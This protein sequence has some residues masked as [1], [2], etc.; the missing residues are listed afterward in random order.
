MDINE[1]VLEFEVWLKKT[2]MQNYSPYLYNRII[3]YFM[4]NVVKNR[5]CHLWMQYKQ[6]NLS[7]YIISVIVFII[8]WVTNEI[9][10][11]PDIPDMNG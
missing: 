2:Y 10:A 1:R 11:H 9:A 4:N 7:Y 6:H 3:L 8:A 5:K